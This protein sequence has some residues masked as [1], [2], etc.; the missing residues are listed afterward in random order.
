MGAQITAA[1][2]GIAFSP[3]EGRTTIMQTAICC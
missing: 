2:F 1:R 3:M